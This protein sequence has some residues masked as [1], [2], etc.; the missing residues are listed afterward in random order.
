MEGDLEQ[1][2]AELFGE[3]CVVAAVDGVE[4]FVRFFDQVGT[5]R[6]MSLLDVPRAAAWGAETLLDRD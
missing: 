5:E 2:V 1:Q 4:D 3:F 6:L